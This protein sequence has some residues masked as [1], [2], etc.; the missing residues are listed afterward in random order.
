MHGRGPTSL[1]TLVHTGPR[2]CRRPAVCTDGCRC[3]R[4]LDTRART[5]T[6][7]SARRVGRV[8][9][10]VVVPSV[11]TTS[12][13]RPRLRSQRT[14]SGPRA[15]A[16]VASMSA[17]V[18]DGPTTVTDATPVGGRPVRA[19]TM[20]AP[21]RAVPEVATAPVCTGTTATSRVGSCG[22]SMPMRQGGP[23]GSTV[24]Q[25]RSPPAERQ[26]SVSGSAARCAAARS[27]A[28]PLTTP[29]GS[30]TPA[31]ADGER[32]AGV[33]LGAPRRAPGPRPPRAGSRRGRSRRGRG[34]RSRSR[35]GRC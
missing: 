10:T 32:A 22:S 28:Q 23:A 27:A 9:T 25:V 17:A 3:A 34:G 24:R 1:T 8:S 7:G 6:T 33:A 29:D 15:K 12:A 21:R 35:R 5:S 14:A 19:S 20:W 13:V 11:C 2:P 18:S 4:R 30:S 31:A 16:A 26:K